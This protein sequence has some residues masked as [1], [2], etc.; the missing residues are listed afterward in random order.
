MKKFLFS[1]VIG[2]IAF[3]L[4]S[5]QDNITTDKG[6]NFSC[7]IYRITSDSAYFY[8]N[9]LGQELGI[10]QITKFS[11]SNKLKQFLLTTRQFDPNTNQL[12]FTNYCI[13]HFKKE[14]GVAKSI[15]F[16]G[17]AATIG[18]IALLNKYLSSQTDVTNTQFRQARLLG[19]S[20]LGLIVIGYIT[21]LH[22]LSWLNN[23]SVASEYKIGFG[24]TFT[25]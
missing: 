17:T 22:S 3:N 5:A 6:L 2:L 24:Y 13:K 19:L 18:S 23:L 21:D 15:F 10:N 8:Y 16:T 14:N 4:L 25:L 12:P 20:G 7:N 9:G 11:S 1:T